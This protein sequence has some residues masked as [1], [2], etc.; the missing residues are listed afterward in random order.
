MKYRR[1][2]KQRSEAAMKIMKRRNENENISVESQLSG[3]VAYRNIMKKRI[4]RSVGAAA[5]RGGKIM[6]GG[7]HGV[8]MAAK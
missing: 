1:H 5:W 8:N 2:R 3:M 4:A 7:N 6:A